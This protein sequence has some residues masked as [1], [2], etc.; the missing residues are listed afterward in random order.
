MAIRLA[1]FDL[2]GTLVRGQTCVVAIASAI[3]RVEECAEFEKLAMRDTAGVTAAREKMARWYRGHT[4]DDLTR[5]LEELPLA[6]GSA[7]G[8]ALLRRSG[9]ETA[10]VSITW[11]FAVDWFAERLGADYAHGTRLT[12]G[13]IEHVWPPDKGRW[14][15][16]LARSLGLAREAIAAVGDSDGDRELLETAGLRF[17]VGRE[18]PDIPEV[19]HVPDA[20]LLTIAREIVEW[21]HD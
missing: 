14:L 11:S 19:I 5:T 7:D 1:A 17:F 10:I 9:V 6:P 20:D 18:P 21:S 12:E 8:F 4:I 3:G 2:D 13:G 16:E 15:H